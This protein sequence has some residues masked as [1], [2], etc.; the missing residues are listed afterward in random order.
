VQDTP[1]SHTLSEAESRALVAAAG[2]RVSPYTTVGSV[3]EVAAALADLAPPWV[4]KLCGATIAHKTERGLVRLGLA[5][6]DEVRSAVADLLAAARPADG[7]VTV[8]VSSMVPGRRELIA[9][10]VA[11]PQFGPV[12]MLGL[13]GVLAEAVRDVG[14]RLAPL[15]PVDAGELIDGLASQGILGEF[16]G[17]PAVDRAALV[18]TLVALGRLAAADPSILSIDCNPLIL[19]DGVPVAVDALVEKAGAR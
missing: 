8:L 13:G 4:A 5:T 16:R 18:E 17:E 3:G 7:A 12:V 14:F 9:G 19:V 11:D 15:Q 6:P 1:G 10:V 2:V